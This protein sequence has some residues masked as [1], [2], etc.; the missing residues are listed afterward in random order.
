MITIV[1]KC[2][3]TQET[4]KPPVNQLATINN[5]ITTDVSTERNPA[6]VQMEINPA[7]HNIMNMEMENNL[8]DAKM[9]G[10]PAYQ[11][12]QKDDSCKDEDDYY[13]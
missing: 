13:Y 10:D 5:G 7:Y 12:L 11:I 2:K 1:K 4:Q 3:K 8:A 9:Q 6:Y